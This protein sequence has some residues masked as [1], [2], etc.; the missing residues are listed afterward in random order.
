MRLERRLLAVP[1][2][3][4]FFAFE[5]GTFRDSPSSYRIAGSMYRLA[6]SPV[7]STGLAL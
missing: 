5:L 6:A 2:A 3:A 7:S 4:F 1:A